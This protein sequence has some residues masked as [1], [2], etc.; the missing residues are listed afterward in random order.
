M[1][2]DPTRRNAVLTKVAL[3]GGGYTGGAAS[4]PPQRT[5][6]FGAGEGSHVRAARPQQQQ[7]GLPAGALSQLAQANQAQG[8]ANMSPFGNQSSFAG[9]QHLQAVRRMGAGM[10]RQNSG[11]VAP[12]TF[13]GPP[14]V[15][16]R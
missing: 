13:G 15:A 16:G 14:Q 9:G 3:W 4:A 8:P 10:F 1:S 7:V 6:S 11:Q 12:G 5:V 2:L